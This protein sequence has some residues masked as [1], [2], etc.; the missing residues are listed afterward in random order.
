MPP[1]IN[2]ICPPAIFFE[3]GRSRTVT[4][5]VQPPPSCRL[6]E[7]ENEY[8]NGGCPPASVSGAHTELR[9]SLSK[10]S[11]RPS[12]LRLNRQM[13]IRRTDRRLLLPL[14]NLHPSRRNQHCRSGLKKLPP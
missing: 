13:M 9:F 1:V 5:R 12:G 8:L 14:R 7:S 10:G 4:C 11:V 2:R 6:C 3:I